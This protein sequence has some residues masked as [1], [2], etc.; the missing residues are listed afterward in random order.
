MPRESLRRGVPSEGRV[1]MGRLVSDYLHE[2]VAGHG[3]ADDPD[4]I[5]YSTNE[6]Y[7][8]DP[9]ITLL[10]DLPEMMCAICQEKLK[11]NKKAEDSASINL[12]ILPCGHIGC[13][14]CLETWLDANQTCPICRTEMIYSQ[15]RHTVI[16]V[17]ITRDTMGYLPK[18]IPKGG[19][20]PPNCPECDRKAVREKKVKMWILAARGIVNARRR[21]R[22]RN[23]GEEDAAM[24]MEIVEDQFRRVPQEYADTL[25]ERRW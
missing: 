22:E 19:S 13:Y 8:P 4:R 16:P 15:C 1:E 11:L 7:F 21:I 6:C 17:L 25:Q 18:T 14:G 9:M 24:I 20:I 23:I 5:Q 12:A 3:H 10:V 2:I